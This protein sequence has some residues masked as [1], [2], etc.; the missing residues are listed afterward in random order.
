MPTNK[1]TLYDNAGTTPVGTCT[2]KTTGTLSNAQGSL[3]CLKT[4]VTKSGN[5]ITV[6]WAITPAAV[7]S[8]TSAK[9]LYMK[10]TDKAGNAT[11]FIQK[12][13]WTII[14]AN[15]P[16]TLGTL[17]PT[18]LS[19]KAGV[20]QSFTATYADQSGNSNIKTTEIQIGTTGNGSASIWARYDRSTNKLYL[21]NDAGTGY[22]AGGGCTPALPG[23]ISNAQGTLHCD[24]TL[25]TKMGNSIT[26]KW[27]IAPVFTGTKDVKMKVTDYSNLTTGFVK[28][29]IW[30]INP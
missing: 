9:K 7:F 30:T 16:P 27:S 29:G 18:A 2:P 1:L 12:G 19:S 5:T 23:S 4:T 26:V 13:T 6:K 8:V 22:V 28:K 25:I 3:N 20:I 10:A 15:Q 17:T 24:Q 21:L 14:G 11:A